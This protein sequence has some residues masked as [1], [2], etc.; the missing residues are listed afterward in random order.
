[1]DSSFVVDS[2][3]GR[4]LHARPAAEEW[5][6]ALLDSDASDGYGQD[7]RRPRGSGRSRPMRRPSRVIVS[8]AA[9]AVSNCQD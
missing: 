3:P 9:D 1:M 7:R 2:L 6:N 5:L 4:V 8:C